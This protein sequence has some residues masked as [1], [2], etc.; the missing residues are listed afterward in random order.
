MQYDGCCVDCKLPGDDCPP[1]I[2]QALINA[3]LARIPKEERLRQQLQPLK[4]CDWEPLS[5]TFIMNK[6]SLF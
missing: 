6:L 3:T 1:G 2:Y 5:P 4:A